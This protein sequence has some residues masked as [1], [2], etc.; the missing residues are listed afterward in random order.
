M[1]RAVLA[2]A[3]VG[4]WLVSCRE[5]PSPEDGVLS[6]SPLLVPSPGLV[7][8]DTMR[9]SLGFVAP[10]RVIAY[11]VSGDPVPGAQPTFVVLDT[12]SHLSGALLIG[13]DTITTEVVGRVA[14][15]QTPAV[16]IPVTLAP[17]ALVAA[18]SVRHLLTPG[19]ADTVAST[20]L[21]ARVVNLLGGAAAAKGIQAVVVRYAVVRAPPPAGADVGPTFLLVPGT[22][23]AAR[24]TTDASGLAERTARFRLLAIAAPE[25]T[26]IIDASASY[27]GQTLGTVQFT[28]VFRKQ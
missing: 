23:S 2:A 6:I 20:S 24:D 13:D 21:R 9:D 8:G 19:V 7:V 1:R 16:R 15:I 22:S 5:I 3:A 10:L 26:A 27:R 14:G 4:W 12:G 11:D 18:D 17:E 28:I 25:D